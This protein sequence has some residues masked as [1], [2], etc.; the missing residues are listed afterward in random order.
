MQITCVRTSIWL[1]KLCTTKP[2]KMQKT[3]GFPG[4]FHGGDGGI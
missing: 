3:P 2:L 1:F 4:V